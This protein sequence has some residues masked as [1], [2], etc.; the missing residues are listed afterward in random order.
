[1]QRRGQLIMTAYDVDQ[2]WF[3]AQLKPNSAKIAVANLT[4]QKI[5]NF[6][7]MEEVTQ[8]RIGKFVTAARPLFPGYIFIFLDVS[9]GLWRKVNST[10]GITKLV[11]FGAEPASVPR[12]LVPELKARCDASGILLPPK[13]FN[14][15]D[16]VTLTTG[17]F[18]NFF[19][20]IEGVTPDRRAWVLIDL[21]GRQTR[22][23]VDTKGLKSL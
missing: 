15:G 17:P 20:E 5:Q 8:Q 18:A 10:Q 3:L 1:M 9:Q 12:D 13:Q 21:M 11:S 16:Q 6:L 19:A 23:A 7:P 4:R 2:K 22:V 14:P